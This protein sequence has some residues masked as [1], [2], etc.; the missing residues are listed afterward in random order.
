MLSIIYSILKLKLRFKLVLFL[1][2]AENQSSMSSSKELYEE[3]SVFRLSELPRTRIPSPLKPETTSSDSDNPIQ[4]G[5]VN[6]TPETHS[7]P[8]T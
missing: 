6:L 3:E 5:I 4:F 8:S 1:G 2:L 7:K